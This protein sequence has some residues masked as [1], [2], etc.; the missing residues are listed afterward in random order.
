MES[1][2]VEKEHDLGKR[3][4]ALYQQKLRAHVETEENIGKIIVMEVDSGDYEIDDL[5]I[6]SSRRL[7][8]RHPGTVLYALRIGYRTVVSFAGGLERTAP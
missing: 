7:Q 3:A 2:I 5:G 8:A 6:E 1:G 4:E